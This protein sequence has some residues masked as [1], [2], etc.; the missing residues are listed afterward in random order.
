MM[1]FRKLDIGRGKR[2]A[3]AKGDC[4]VRALAVAAGMTYEEAWHKLYQLQ[5]RYRTAGFFLVKWLDIVPQELAVVRRFAFPA[6]KGKSR[7]TGEEFCKEHRLG[8]YIL[9]LAHHV[10]AVEDG[11]LLDSW[12]CTDRC[13]YV[14]WKIGQVP[15][16][17][18]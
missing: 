5:G 17:A 7:M 2:P 12:D 8:N 15:A 13:V 10:A 1:V 4:Q 9:R 11:V 14:A 6:V 16:E 18:R 3:W